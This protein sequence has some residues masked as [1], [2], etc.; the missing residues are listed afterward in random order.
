M[1]QQAHATHTTTSLL[2]TQ[3]NTLYSSFGNLFE[4]CSSY[5]KIIS[6]KQSQCCAPETQLT[7]E[8]QVLRIKCS[9]VG[10]PFQPQMIQINKQICKDEQRVQLC[11]GRRPTP[12]QACYS[13][14]SV[15]RYRYVSRFSFWF[16]I[17]L[18]EG[19][20]YSFHSNPVAHNVCNLSVLVMRVRRHFIFTR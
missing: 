5:N 10:D 1:I 4:P 11:L 2:A 17:S 18:L 16:V 13:F 20:C 6:T 7:V 12:S 9:Q 14:L 19:S 8:E 15:I 3:M